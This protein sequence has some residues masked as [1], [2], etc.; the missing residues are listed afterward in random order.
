M[1]TMAFDEGAGEDD[2]N[3]AL[4]LKWTF[5]F[6]SKLVSGVHSLTVGE[7]FALFYVSAHSGVIYNATERS[8]K[9]LQGHKVSSYQKPF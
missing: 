2:D 4:R 3:A 7:Q 5:G 9:I 1:N 6:N 8:Q